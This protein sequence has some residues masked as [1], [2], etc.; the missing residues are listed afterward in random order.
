M[1]AER[2]VIRRTDRTPCAL[3][4]TAAQ[5]D[6]LLQHAASSLAWR[7]D[8]KL[9]GR[10]NYGTSPKEG[11]EMAQMDRIGAALIHF[12]DDECEPSSGRTPY[13]PSYGVGGNRALDSQ[14][15]PSLL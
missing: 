10:S 8:R 15:P 7:L 11:A 1:S 14:R 4:Y 12:G 6:P 9:L 2:T 13:R 5:K 3:L